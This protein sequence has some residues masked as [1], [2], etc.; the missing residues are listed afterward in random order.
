MINAGM[1]FEGTVISI[2]IG[3][4]L[5]VI[6]ISIKCLQDYNKKNREDKILNY[7][8]RK[9][10][11]C[12]PC[13]S[14]PF[15]FKDNLNCFIDKQHPTYNNVIEKTDKEKVRL[16]IGELQWVKPGVGPAMI[17]KYQA[18]YS[19]TM[20]MDSTIDRFKHSATMCVLYDDGFKL[21]NFTL[22]RETLIDKTSEVLKLNSTEDIDFDDDKEFSD[23]WWLSSNE[24]MIAKDFFDKNVRKSFM[25]YSDRNYMI[26]GL[27]EMILIIADNVYPP[28]KY[29]QIEADIKS[30]AAFLRK[31][32]KYYEKPKYDC[33]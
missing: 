32:E 17:S 9:G 31:N 23:T 26:T 19:R 21:P 28:E 5:L 24:N 1:G 3:F 14:E 8:K 7:A 22:A 29:T 16:Y 30:I 2:G 12:I 33:L 10:L 27:R 18:D 13:F 20:G 4:L 11:R 15:K 25:K 6:V